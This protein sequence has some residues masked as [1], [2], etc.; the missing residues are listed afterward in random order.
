MRRTGLTRR[1][2]RYLEERS[3]LGPVARSD[4]RTVYSAPQLEFLE[5][6]AR[7]RLLGVP[8]EEAATVAHALQGG[9]SGVPNSRLDELVSAALA[10]AE[11]NARLGRDLS[12]LRARRTAQGRP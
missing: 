11:R 1:Q 2:L 12:T 10:N 8:V 7:L 9:S 5:H 4:G 3:H 6:V